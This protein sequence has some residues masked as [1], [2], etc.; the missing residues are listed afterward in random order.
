MTN[1]LYRTVSGELTEDQAVGC[2]QVSNVK[3]AKDGPYLCDIRAS[4][5][6][7]NRGFEDADTLALVGETDQAGRPRRMFGRLDIGALECQDD[8]LP[9]LMLLFR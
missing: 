1:C 7:F 4:S 9:G 3:W 6:A 8:T 5:K 2:W